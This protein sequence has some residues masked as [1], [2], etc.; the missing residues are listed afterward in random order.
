MKKCIKN[1]KDLFINIS[2]TLIFYTLF[3]NIAFITYFFIYPHIIHPLA[4]PSDFNFFIR[5]FAIKR[6]FLGYSKHNSF[7]GFISQNQKVSFIIA[8]DIFNKV[9]KDLHN[10]N[11]IE[12]NTMSMSSIMSSIMSN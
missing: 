5:S 4:K 9:A 8:T 1:F 7:L 6:L 10:I 11:L 2:F 3:T 12:K